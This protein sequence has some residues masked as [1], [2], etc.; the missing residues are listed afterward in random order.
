VRGLSV[1]MVSKPSHIEIRSFKIV[2]D[3]E[4]L[5][6]PESTLEQFVK[7]HGFA[8]KPPRYRVVDV[9]IVACSED[10]QPVLV[11][12]C[13][14]CRRFIRRYEGSICCRKIRYIEK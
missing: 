5:F 10:G 11:T 1:E 3:L 6:A 14:K 13:G 9:E 12:E 8:P 4:D 7:L 2:V